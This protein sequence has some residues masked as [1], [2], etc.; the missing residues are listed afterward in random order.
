MPSLDGAITWL[1]SPPLSAAQLRGKVVLVDFWT[2]TCVNWR[3]T[4][5]YVRV[6]ANKYRDGAAPFRWTRV[7]LS[8]KLLVFLDSSILQRSAV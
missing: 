2:Y 8:S 7:C 1:N 4:L 3:R 6:W 5:P